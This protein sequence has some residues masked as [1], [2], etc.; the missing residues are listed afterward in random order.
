MDGIQS[1]VFFFSSSL[2]KSRL[3]CPIRQQSPLRSVSDRPSSSRS[4][5]GLACNAS[6]PGHR[7]L[8]SVTPDYPKFYIVELQRTKEQFG[9]KKTV[10]LYVCL[11]WHKYL[12]LSPRPRGKLGLLRPL[13]CRGVNH[14]GRFA[15]RITSVILRTDGLFFG[16]VRSRGKGCSNLALAEVPSEKKQLIGRRRD[17]YFSKPYCGRVPLSISFRLL[18]PS[19]EGHHPSRSPPCWIASQQLFFLRFKLRRAQTLWWFTEFSCLYC[20][21]AVYC[22]TRVISNRHASKS[23]QPSADVHSYYRCI[24]RIQSLII[25]WGKLQSSCCCYFWL[26]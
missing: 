9:R 16:D 14:I 5:W 24:E 1:S 17:A 26:F 12:K 23:L 3:E 19:R 18:L 4:M 22:V 13:Y 2:P 21:R 15:G 8:N 6:L 11:Y 7:F 20:K 10:K 25:T